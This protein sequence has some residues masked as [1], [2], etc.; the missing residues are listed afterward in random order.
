MNA[1]LA[2]LLFFIFLLLFMG[3]LWSLART[4]I[5]PFVLQRKR[6]S[7]CQH[8][9]QT[10]NQDTGQGVHIETRFCPK[11]AAVRTLGYGVTAGVVKKPA[12]PPATKPAPVKVQQKQGQRSWKV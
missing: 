8:E 1:N 12:A 10:F 9:F 4:L 11:C 2:S 5:E 7:I 6:E 3:F